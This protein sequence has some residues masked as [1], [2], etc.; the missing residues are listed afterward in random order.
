[1]LVSFLIFV[2]GSL[3]LILF[4]GLL[5]SLAVAFGIKETED[6]P[7]FWW[8]YII[9]FLIPLVILIFLIKLT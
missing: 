6:P 5:L 9:I 7:G 1:M 8:P 4:I 2:V 3:S